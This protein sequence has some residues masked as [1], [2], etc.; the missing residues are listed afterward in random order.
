M[1]TAHMMDQSIQSSSPVVRP[2]GPSFFSQTP[3]AKEKC[4]Y[5]YLKGVMVKLKE[6]KIQL[7]F[8]SRILLIVLPHHV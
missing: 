3:W 2:V 5:R 8:Y 6:L 7:C 1:L 4:P